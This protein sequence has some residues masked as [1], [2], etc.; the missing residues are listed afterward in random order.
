KSQPS[1]TVH[2]T[3]PKKIN[4]SPILLSTCQMEFRPNSC[5]HHTSQRL[6]NNLL[7]GHNSDIFIDLNTSPQFY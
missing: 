1:A 7:I 6:N 4:Y 5:V 3:M 2:T